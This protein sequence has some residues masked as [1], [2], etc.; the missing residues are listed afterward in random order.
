MIGPAFKPVNFNAELKKLLGGPSS[1]MPWTPGPLNSMPSLLNRTFM[2]MPR[3]VMHSY[4]GMQ[5]PALTPG[6][7]PKI[8]NQGVFGMPSLGSVKR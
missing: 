1:F 5:D 4:I 3:V 7:Q 6:A 2:R 8:K